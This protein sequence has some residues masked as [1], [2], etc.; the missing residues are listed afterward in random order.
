MNLRTYQDKMVVSLA[1]MLTRCRKIVGQLATGGGKTVIFS[2][3]AARY[4]TKAKKSVLILVHR[5]ELLAQTRK[6]AYNSFGLVCESI[7]A[8]CKYIPPAELYVGMVE[9]VNRRIAKLPKNIGLVIIDE[10]HRLEFVKLHQYFPE[11]YIIGFTATPLTASKKKPLK[12]YYEDI[13]C[14]VDIPQLISEGHLC[15]NI[16]WAPKD[17]VDRMELAIK[18]GEFDDGMM[19][20]AFSKPRYI[21]NTVTAYTKWAKGTKAII[22]NVNIDHSK[23]VT[24]A[25]VQAGYPCKHL[26]GYESKGDREKVLH[27]FANTAGAI[28][29]NIGIA[30]T[31]FDEPTIET[32][33]VNKATLSMPLWLQMCGRGSRPIPNRK[34]AF[35][36]IDMGG[37]ALA[38]GDWCQSRDWVSIFHDPPK[39]GKPTAGPV[40]SC[41]NCDAIIPAGAKVCPFCG[42]VYE[43]K[44]S[45]EI[46]LHDFVVVTKNI[47]VEKIIRDNARKK[48]YYPFFKIGSDLAQEAKNTI[49]KMSDEYA[50]FIAQIYF[51][52]AK[53]WA[54]KVGKRFNKWMQLKAEEHIY[55]QLRSRYPEWD[56]ELGPKNHHRETIPDLHNLQPIQN[57]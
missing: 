33:I 52:L 1:T 49:P 17:T 46:E 27:W 32:V 9:T 51:D 54:H 20:Q 6:T 45:P 22:F 2:A 26:D 25:F 15:Q 48:F 14:G 43:K 34:S 44:I 13:V 38:H 47:D 24:D 19:A 56:T 40:K 16:T 18:N 23:V 3:I 36:I 57:L 28:L 31:G 53:T 37:N 7:V 41:P 5:K 12:D 35:T 4:I 50:I 10:C 11:Q 55:D 39:A 29:C 30:T 42:F 8:G 21:H